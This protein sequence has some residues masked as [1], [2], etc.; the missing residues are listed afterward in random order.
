M[1]KL[2]LEVWGVILDSPTAQGVLVIIVC[3]IV[4]YGG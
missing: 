2:F 4:Y 1:K 3:Q